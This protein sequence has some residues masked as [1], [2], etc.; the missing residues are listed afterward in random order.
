MKETE[1]NHIVAQLLIIGYDDYIMLEGKRLMKVFIEILPA[2]EK[3]LITA[4]SSAMASNT[5]LASIFLEAVKQY[6]KYNN[7]NN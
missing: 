1:G 7:Q 5:Q 3:D 6:N 4:V 2:T